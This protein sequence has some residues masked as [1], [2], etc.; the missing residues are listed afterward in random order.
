M[1]TPP[2]GEWV[3]FGTELTDNSG[4]LTF[5]IPKEKSLSQGIYPVKMVVR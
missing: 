4:R 2:T 1:T 5:E 3:S